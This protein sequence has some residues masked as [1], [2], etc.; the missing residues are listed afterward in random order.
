[1]AINKVV[2]TSTKS[3]GA[4]RNV[5]EYVLRDEK[6]KEGYVDISGPYSG[7]TINYDEIYQSWL[8][9]KK[10][11]DKDSGRMYSH[12]V[13]SFH[14]DEKITPKQVLDIGK[15]LAEKFYSG[16]QYV[17]GVHQDKKHL[18]C[19]IVTNSVS[20]IDGRK[21]HQTKKDLQRQKD[22]TNDICRQQG[23]SVAEKGK[24]FDGSP[25]DQ[26]EVIVWNKD[27]YNLLANDSKKS[28]LAECALAIINALKQCFNKEMFIDNMKNQGW[29]VNWNETKKHITFVNEEG[30]K[31]RDTNISKTF[32][33][34][35]SKK[36]LLNEF[37]RQNTIRTETEELSEYYAELE[38]V[39]SSR[40]H[41]KA[42]DNDQST[43]IRSDN[44]A[45]ETE[46]ERTNN[47]DSFIRHSQATSRSNKVKQRK[48]GTERND[49]ETERERQAA[50]AREQA[51]AAERA[52]QE[53]ARGTKE[54]S[55]QKRK[56]HQSFR[57]RDYGPSL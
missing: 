19:H 51:E 25:I 31:V 43:G 54:E 33:M 18:H 34:N 36:D 55:G 21:L 4:M 6:V 56:E 16:H 1:M 10:L 7:A 40:A 57:R 23:L 48:S 30:S 9:E 12:H 26:G 44:N 15:A 3:H 24:H 17:I 2:N 45:R 41:R 27:K 29:S 50:A 52:R 37:E 20:Y 22:F 28:F 38:H 39:Q 46:S 35:I 53:S 42:I 14:Q 11:W 5:L 47:I 8:A 49:R 13:I 32:S